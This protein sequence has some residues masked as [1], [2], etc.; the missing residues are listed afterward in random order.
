MIVGI[1]LLSVFSCIWKWENVDLSGS[2]VSFIMPAHDVKLIAV[3]T[4]STST[5][6]T[7]WNSWQ[8]TWW[9]QWWSHSSWWWGG[10]GWGG[11]WWGG[12]WWNQQTP[13]PT[14]QQNTGVDKPET[15]T[16]HGAAVCAWEDIECV[17]KWAYSNWITT[18]KTLKAADPDGYVKRWHMAKM[19]VN[20]MVNILWRPMPKETPSECLSLKAWPGWWESVEIKQYA[21][22]SCKLWIMW[23][24]MKDNEFLPN[25]VVSRAEFG[26]ILSRILWWDK[27]NVADSAQIRYYQKHLQAL[28]KNWIMTQ[29]SDPEVRKEL[30]KRV[31]LMLY[32]SQ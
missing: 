21:V 4:G 12:W 19:V 7:W 15:N 16:G 5:V 23:I 24:N 14:P 8:N 13:K 25:N 1:V 31:W 30:R 27:Y 32:R 29:I 28:K 17:Y 11:G 3:A 6:D 9:N 20:F 18:M 26:T 10:W 22:K 2:N